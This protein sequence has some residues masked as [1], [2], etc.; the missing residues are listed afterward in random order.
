MRSS[1]AARSSAWRSKSSTSSS[2]AAGSPAAGSRSTRPP[3]GSRS[4]SSEREDF[5]SGTS[6][7]S[8]RLIHGGVRYL[9]QRELGLVRESLRERAIILR[10]APH[11]LRTL[12]I[13]LPRSELAFRAAFTIYDLLALGVNVA[14]HRRVDADELDRV[15]PGLEHRGGGFVYHECA[16]DDARLTL[17]IAR[18]AAAHGALVANHARVDGLIGEGRV[19][20]ATVRDEL[21][22]ETA[23]G[24]SEDDRQRDRRV[25][26]AASVACHEP[27]E[28]AR[29]EQGDPPR[30]PPRRGPRAR[31]AAGSVGRGRP[32]LRVRDPVGGPLLRR[33]DRYRVRG[34]PR[35]TGGRAERCRLR[36]RRGCAC[37]SR[38]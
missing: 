31:R 11:L 4:G 5:A 20:G 35:D 18:A 3:A 36:P 28:A 8:S 9:A 1:A 6:G 25:V 10:L 14:R 17:E 33:H 13:Y 12:P 24:P 23:G 30:L 16:T 22:G 21:T 7:R 19:T 37:R 2:W 32:P 27:S 38:T 34:R 15:A 29:R 26:G